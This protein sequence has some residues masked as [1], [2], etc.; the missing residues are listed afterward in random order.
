MTNPSPT[1]T[2]V[3]RATG[4]QSVPPARWVTEAHLQRGRNAHLACQ[5]D[6]EGELDED[7][8]TPEL[9]GYLAA[10]RAAR[11][12]LGIIPVRWEHR[13]HDRWGRFNGQPDL[14][15]WLRDRRATCDLKTGPPAPA[16]GV[17]CEAY[18]ILAADQLDWVSQVSFSLHIRPDKTYAVRVYDPDKRRENEALWWAALR[19]YH[20]RNEHGLLLPEETPRAPETP[21]EREQEDDLR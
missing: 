7:S 5:L 15:C 10:Y 2:R 9:A 14:L 20:F 16:I 8:L 4:I 13:L 17:Q 1:V 18:T 3:L 19:L 21:G 11:R 12:D 6:D